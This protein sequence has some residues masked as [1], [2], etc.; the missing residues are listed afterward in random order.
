M[1]GG[2]RAR[3]QLLGVVWATGGCQE[4][5]VQDG[6]AAQARSGYKGQLDTRW[7][8]QGL[9]RGGALGERWWGWDTGGRIRDK[10]GVPDKGWGSRQGMGFQSCDGTPDTGEFPDRDSG[11]RDRDG[12]VP[13][14]DGE[15]PK[16][17][18]GFETGDGIPDAGGI[19][20]RG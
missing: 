12:G 19:P 13:D 16:G 20:D 11:V 18:V 9:N 1:A 17:M 3:W 15:V 7:G 4:A 8:L 6:G 10:D 5:E 2:R 14:R